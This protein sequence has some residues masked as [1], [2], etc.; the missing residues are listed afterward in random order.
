[1]RRHE[2]MTAAGALVLGVLLLGLALRQGN[3]QVFGFPVLWSGLMVLFALGL[4]LQTLAWPARA[5]AGETTRAPSWLRLLPAL[6]VGVVYLALLQSLG[7]YA[8]T[9]VA[10]VVLT[11][12]YA[13]RPLDRRLMLARLLLATAFV[14][15]LHLLF[16]TALG[17]QTPR[18][19]LR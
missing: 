10:F 12:L 3:L 15:A 18:G 17:I 16:S 14:F 7:F 1:M 4:V 13:P 2:V 11:L 19:W 8:S 9:W 5:E 6:G